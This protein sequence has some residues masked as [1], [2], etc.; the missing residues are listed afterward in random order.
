[1]SEEQTPYGGYD[2]TVMGYSASITNYDRKIHFEDY[3]FV[4]SVNITG[5]EGTYG[6]TVSI[7]G[8]FV[9]IKGANQAKIDFMQRLSDMNLNL[10][11][12][13]FVITKI[14]ICQIDEKIIASLYE[15]GI[16][17]I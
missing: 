12:C 17:R 14:K 6:S 5:R 11:Q 10:N 1:M 7:I 16:C 3:A 9:S 15:S 8:V 4:L 2:P 13:T